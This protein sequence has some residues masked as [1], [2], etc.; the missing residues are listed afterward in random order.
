MQYPLVKE[1]E[2]RLWKD[3]VESVLCI[4]YV[5]QFL[6]KSQVFQLIVIMEYTFC[7][8]LKIFCSILIGIQISFYHKYIQVYS[9]ILINHL[10]VFN[11]QQNQ[12]PAIIKI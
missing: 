12:H 7:V 5:R 8:C 11:A 2:D 10:N 9:T 1:K 6:M 4:L 3:Q